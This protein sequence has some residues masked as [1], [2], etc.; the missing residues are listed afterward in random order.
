[1]SSGVR[2]QASETFEPLQTAS[3]YWE[4]RFPKSHT[5]IATEFSSRLKLSLGLQHLLERPKHGIQ[6]G[7]QGF[8]KPPIH[9]TNCTIK[10]WKTENEQERKMSTHLCKTFVTVSVLVALLVMAT[11]DSSAQS[12]EFRKTVEFSSGGEVRV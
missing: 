9:L 7:V 3:R 10:K 12:R 4:S 1:M 8:G 2:Y 11:P 6:F 5:R